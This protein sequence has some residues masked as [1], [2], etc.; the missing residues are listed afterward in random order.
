MNFLASFLLLIVL[1][2]GVGANPVPPSGRFA[3]PGGPDLATG[4]WKAVAENSDSAVVMA[5]A[6]AGGQLSFRQPNIG[7]VVTTVISYISYECISNNTF[8]ATTEGISYPTL[9]P[10]SQC[11]IY[12]INETHRAVNSL[13]LSGGKCPNA[14]FAGFNL[15]P[16]GA[17]ASSNI[18]RYVDGVLPRPTSFVCRNRTR[19]RLAASLPTYSPSLSS[20]RPVQNNSTSNITTVTLPSSILA[21]LPPTPPAPPPPSPPPPSPPSPFSTLPKS[22]GAAVP[23]GIWKTSNIVEMITR[24]G[25][26]GNFYNPT[27]NELIAKRAT[28]VNHE[29]ADSDSYIA[30]AEQTWMYLNGTTTA[31][32]P[33]CETGEKRFGDGEEVLDVVMASEGTECPSLDEVD[34]TNGV[35]PSNLMRYSFALVEP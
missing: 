11:S 15:G 17:Y 24:D 21:P 4:V 31:L 18:Y 19:S 27:T 33:S 6:D 1:S 35:Q 9:A 12:F 26:Y 14:A 23:L 25:F 30:T 20:I 16:N 29:C 3:Y 28:Y 32:L 34:D 2:T 7:E 8:V 10:I 5:V 13:P 22:G